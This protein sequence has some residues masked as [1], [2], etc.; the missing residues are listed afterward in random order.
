MAKH[1]GSKTIAIILVRGTINVSPDVRTTL[2]LLNL[3]RKNQCSIIKN[4][5]SNMGMIFKVKDYVTYGEIDAETLKKLQEKRGVK[6]KKG[7]LKS[8]FSLTPPKG[9]FE[10]KGIKKSFTVGGALGYRGAEINNLIEKMI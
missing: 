1:D 6:D 10:R 9:G 5:E 7:Q 3:Q 2:K 4:T 8:F